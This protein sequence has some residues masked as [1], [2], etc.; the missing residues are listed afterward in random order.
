MLTWCAQCCPSLYCITQ[1][2]KP[3]LSLSH[4]WLLVTAWTVALQA[5]LSTGCSRQEYWSGLPFPSPGDL[6][7]LS[8]KYI[9]S[10][11][12]I[13]WRVNYWKRG[14]L[15]CLNL[16]VN[17]QWYVFQIRLTFTSCQPCLIALF[18]E[19]MGNGNLFKE[20]GQPWGMG[21][22]GRWEGGSGWG[23]HVHPWLIHVHVSQNP[24]QYCKVISL[25]LKF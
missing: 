2:T 15:W 11:N 9:L 21:W 1:N 12:R 19:T 16:H 3:W 4:V 17:I 7:S 5:P 20:L 22:G 24:A 8:N 14:S 23:T 13:K 18:S 10:I 6:P 25:Q